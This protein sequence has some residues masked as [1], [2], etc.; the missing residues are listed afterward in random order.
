MLLR[1]WLFVMLADWMESVN[2]RASGL[3]ALGK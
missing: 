2:T 1:D 3:E